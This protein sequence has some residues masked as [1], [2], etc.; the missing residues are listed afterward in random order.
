M[1]LLERSVASR[2]QVGP[3]LRGTC[4]QRNMRPL[5]TDS[6]DLG[7][8]SVQLDLQ[9]EVLT[10]QSHR[11]GRAAV[12]GE[13]A[14]TIHPTDQQVVEGE[15]DRSEEELGHVQ[16]V[17]LT[18]QPAAMGSQFAR[19]SEL[20]GSTLKAP[21]PLISC[22]VAVRSM[23]ASA[24]LATLLSVAKTTGLDSAY[25]IR[26]R[27]DSMPKATSRRLETKAPWREAEPTTQPQPEELS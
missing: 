19:V 2:D 26:R 24:A 14:E 18:S 5:A 6:G 3:H 16:P 27:A 13:S 7:S 22:L 4:S 11:V 9:R 10:V 15:L 21:N 8:E 12:A 1:V 17:S 25:R 23:L 20:F